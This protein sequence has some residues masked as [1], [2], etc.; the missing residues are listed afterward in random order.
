VNSVEIESR[1]MDDGSRKFKGRWMPE[2]RIRQDRSGLEERILQYSMCDGD[3]I[4][5]WY[6][7]E[8]GEEIELDQSRSAP[9]RSFPNEQR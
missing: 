6:D 9:G 1:E 5:G 4:L 7:R 8:T 3:L 2:F